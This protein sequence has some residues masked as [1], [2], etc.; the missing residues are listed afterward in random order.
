MTDT[1]ESIGR[2]RWRGLLVLALVFGAGLLGGSAAERLRAARVTPDE[3][4]RPPGRD[5]LPPGLERLGLTGAQRDSVFA[6]LD[7]ARP[8]TDSLMRSVMPA[9]RAVMDSTRERIEA[10]LTP[11]QRARFRRERPRGRPAD[12]PPG[13]GAPEGPPP[14]GP[15]PDGPPGPPPR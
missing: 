11:E 6:I 10:V 14:F 1:I 13:L 15:P 2:M 5:R 7:R 3:P 8:H 9:L 4:R 12:A